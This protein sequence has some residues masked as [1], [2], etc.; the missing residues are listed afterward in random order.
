MDANLHK[1]YKGWRNKC[2]NLVKAGHIQFTG[3]NITE[4]STMNEIWKTVNKILAPRESSK[5]TIKV[6]G[7]V[8][9]KLEDPEHVAD[10]LNHWF[11]EKLQKLVNLRHSKNSI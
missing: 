11:K 5:L 1:E 2:N 3:T 7:S 6:K 8:Q 9:G 4:T 10:E